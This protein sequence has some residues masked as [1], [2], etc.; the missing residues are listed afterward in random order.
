MIFFKKQLFVYNENPS[1]E[2]AQKFVHLVLYESAKFR[3]EVK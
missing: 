3:G 2:E 1:P